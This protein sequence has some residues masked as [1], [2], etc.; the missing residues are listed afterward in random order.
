MLKQVYAI[1]LT[2]TLLQTNEMNHIFQINSVKWRDF[3]ENDISS[4]VPIKFKLWKTIIKKLQVAKE[5]I[6]KII[7]F[8]KKTEKVAILSTGKESVSI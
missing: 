8:R 7:W 5:K 6:I 3:E 1:P 2:H 4:W